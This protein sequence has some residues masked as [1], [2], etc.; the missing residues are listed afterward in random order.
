M[1]SLDRAALEACAAEY[2]AAVDGDP[3]V[4]RF[5]TRSD[6]ILPF[7]DAFQPGSELVAARSGGSFALLASRGPLLEPL[8]AMWGF[9][10]PLVGE[11]CVELLLELVASR[12]RT[13]QRLHL[14]GLPPRGA[15]TRALVAGLEPTHA[16]A[17]ASVTER[18]VAKLDD[19]D[20]YLSRR[21][22]KFR[23]GLR[24][25]QRR[26]AGAGISFEALEGVTAAGAAAAYERVLAV[27]RRSW[28]SASENGVD[29][30]PMRAFYAGMFPRLAARGALS[31][32]FAMQDGEGVGYL[33]GGRAGHAFR[34]L[35]FSFDERL[36]PLGLGNVLQAEMIAR[37]S[38][39]GVGT[40]D[41][42]AQSA[43]KARWAEGRLLTV[44]IFA[45]PLAG[46]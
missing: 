3:D 24:A 11:S 29:R 30:G 22:A 36:R 8:E 23:A 13:G 18:F 2:D 6:W 5:C 25:A 20:G 21:S 35:Q 34:G 7:H 46:K 39:A 33:A 43:Y 42:G 10:S 44:G 14:S 12:G 9:A 4:D 38:L 45:Q 17:V 37:L 27:E 1:K 41:L 19:W 15:R 16:L 40:Y 26:V 28:K 32:L 31:L